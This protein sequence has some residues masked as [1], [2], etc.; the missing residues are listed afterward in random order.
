MAERTPMRIYTDTSVF[1][2]PF[3]DEFRN[4]SISFFDEVRL[5]RMTLVVSAVVTAELTSAPQPVRDL[6]DEMVS[7]AEVIEVT[8]AAIALQAA[9]LEAGILTEKWSDD[10]LH[11]ALASVARCDAIASW[12]FRHIVNYRR[13]PLYSAV[14]A[15]HGLPPLRIHAPPEL[16]DDEANQSQ[17]DL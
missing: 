8:E 14:N 5:G 7:E 3:D 10:A 15:L 17:E 2:G 4:A 16:I 13:I 9:Y 12:N 1:G 6:F 11:V